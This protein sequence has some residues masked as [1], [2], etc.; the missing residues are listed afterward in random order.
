MSW[1]RHYANV[2]DFK[3]DVPEFQT[4]QSER[5]KSIVMQQVNAGREAARMLLESKA[6]GCTCKDYAVS[7][8]GHANP[9]HEPQEGWA[10]DS[11]TVTVTQ[12][13]P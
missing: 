13:L 1:S 2:A 7:I 12:K 3:L 8:S 10:T 6:V 5:D 11:I 9:K 4:N